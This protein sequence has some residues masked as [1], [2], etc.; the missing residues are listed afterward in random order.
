LSSSWICL[1]V[2]MFTSSKTRIRVQLLHIRNFL[3]SG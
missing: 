3:K 2:G 1:A